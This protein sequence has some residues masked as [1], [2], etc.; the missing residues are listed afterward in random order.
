ME[1]ELEFCRKYI[2][3][4]A[5][6]CIAELATKIDRDVVAPYVQQLLEGLLVCFHDDSWPVRDAACHACGDFVSVYCDESRPVL[7]ELYHLWFQHLGDNI[8]SVRECAAV[9]LGKVVKAFGT[10][11]DGLARM[12]PVI[13]EGILKVKT[14]P[15]DSQKYGGLENTTTFGV[16][17]KKQRDNDEKLH[18]DQ[19]IYSCGS[20]APK[21][22]KGKRGGGC[23]D[24]AFARDTEP[25]E[26]TDGCVYAVRELSY[27]HPE[28][29]E[30]FVPILI[31]IAHIRHF[32]HH[33]TLKVTIWKA[34]PVIGGNINND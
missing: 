7:D 26:L 4:G 33:H 3:E 2:R 23:M 1:S 25:W 8:P 9:A 32:A 24:H 30:E 14:Q 11:D 15:S 18:A 28:L 16:A 29:M 10:G 13:R 6:H 31:D 27:S 21:L 12:L 17:A 34:I 5:C 19:Q 22:R 20:L